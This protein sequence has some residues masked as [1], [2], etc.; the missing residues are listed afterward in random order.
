M[1]CDTN[2]DVLRNIAAEWNAEWTGGEFDTNRDV[3]QTHIGLTVA[4]ATAAI[5]DEMNYLRDEL[6]GIRA[7][8]GKAVAINQRAE[9]GS[10]F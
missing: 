8:I 2:R 9:R 10:A 3:L 6:A 4:V 5:I 7:T 1:G